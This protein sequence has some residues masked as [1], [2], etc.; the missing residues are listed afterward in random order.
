MNSPQIVRSYRI[1]HARAYVMDN[2]TEHLISGTTLLASYFPKSCLMIWYRSHI[3]KTKKALDIVQHWFEMIS[4]LHCVWSE[5][6]IW[7]ENE[8]K[9]FVRQFVNT[10]PYNDC[11]NLFCDEESEV[12]DAAQNVTTKEVSD[13]DRR[14]GIFS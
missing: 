9:K 12:N 11:V 13:S 1:P 8:G 10:L 4:P 7:G 2:G 6:N 14:P 3:L 5:V